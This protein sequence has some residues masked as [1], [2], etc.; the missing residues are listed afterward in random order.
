MASRVEA[1]VAKHEDLSLIPRN[2]MLEGETQLNA[3]CPL[4]V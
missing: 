4:T 2:C 3:R 1:L